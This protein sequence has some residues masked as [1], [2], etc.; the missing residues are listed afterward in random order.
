[1]N[2]RVKINEEWFVKEMRKLL[3]KVDTAMQIQWHGSSK[4]DFIGLHNN[5]KNRY[6]IHKLMESTYIHNFEIITN[7]IKILWVTSFHF[8][9]NVIK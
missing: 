5:S 3:R 7:L 2:W 4:S 8:N 9:V 1:M 6:L